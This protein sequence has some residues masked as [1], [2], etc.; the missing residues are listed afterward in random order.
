MI[1]SERECKKWL[2]VVKKLAVAFAVADTHELVCFCFVLIELTLKLKQKWDKM[3][4]QKEHSARMDSIL[5]RL[6]KKVSQF[7]IAL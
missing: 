5:I 2:K 1:P 4:K 3:E 6:M 7:T